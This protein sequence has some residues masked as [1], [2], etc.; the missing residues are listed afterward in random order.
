MLGNV[1]NDIAL[2]KLPRPAI[3]N[4]GVQIVCLPLQAENTARQ[5]NIP[6]LREGLIGTIPVVVGWGYQEYDPWAIEQQGDF[7]EA[8][9]ASKVQQKLGVPIVSSYDC[10]QKFERFEPES[11][12]ICA[13]G[14]TGKDSCRV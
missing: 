10:G 13:G 5:L 12:Q 4:S 3:L 14:E 2:V 1:L 9:V 6:N 8:N 11:T 7:K